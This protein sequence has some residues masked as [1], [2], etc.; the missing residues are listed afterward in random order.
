MHNNLQPAKLYCNPGYLVQV[1]RPRFVITHYFK[2]RSQ[3]TSYFYTYCVTRGLL[4][5]P[6]LPR[7]TWAREK[8]ETTTVDFEQIDVIELSLGF[9]LN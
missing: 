3:A 5:N 8:N 7:H 1:T 4:T 2:Y 6:L 9:D